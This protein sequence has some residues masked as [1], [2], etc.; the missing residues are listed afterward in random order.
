MDKYE[1]NIKNY[2]IKL[3]ELDYKIKSGHVDPKK[4]FEVLNQIFVLEQ[5]I[6]LWLIQYLILIILL[7]FLFYHHYPNYLF[8]QFYSLAD[9]D[10]L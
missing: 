7:M 4:G 3:A 9:V 6:L 5:V 2:I 10:N 1:E 8:H